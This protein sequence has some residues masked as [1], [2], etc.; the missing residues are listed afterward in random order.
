MEIVKKIQ[1]N[2]PQPIESTNQRNDWVLYGKDNLYPQFLLGL[3][4]KSPIHKA[5]QTGKIDLTKGK[6]F[7]VPDNSDVI[8]NIIMSENRDGDDWEDLLFK[9]ATDLILFNSFSL[10]LIWSKDRNS[11]AE[12]IHLPVANIRAEKETDGV[13]KNYYYSDSWDYNYVRK[14]PPTVIKK[15]DLND[16]KEPR[17]LY[18]YKAYDGSMSI[19]PNP[20]YDAAIAWILT[21]WHVAK[22]HLNNVA[23]GFTADYIFQL[24]NGVPEP[25]D[26]E[27][28]KETIDREFANSE[29]GKYIL[30]FANGEGQAPTIIKIPETGSDSKYV[31]VNEMILQNLCTAN[32][33]TSLM[34]LGI[35]T[36]GQLGGRTEMLDS[37]ELYQKTVI[38]GYQQKILKFFNKILKINGYTDVELDIIDAK[39]LAEKP[40]ESLL[41]KIA[42]R[43]EIREMYGLEIIEETEEVEEEIIQE[44]EITE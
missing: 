27:E 6:G 25:K 38:D 42:D 41:L 23:N 22:Y 44:E 26:Q 5:I 36:S 30:T 7:E 18:V 35:K 24:N 33:V 13:I 15:F 1:F 31:E 40:T 3:M 14:N 4:E 39:P 12:I 28:I 2:I 29:G 10:Q 37:F 16:R 32:R 34:V 20:E 8:W 9:M 21:D 19:Y 43:N 17:Q 11:I